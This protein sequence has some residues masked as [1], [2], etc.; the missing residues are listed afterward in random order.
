[1]KNKYGKHSYTKT[2]PKN[3]S[4]YITL[5]Q[6]A[7]WTLENALVTIQ[8]P[9]SIPFLVLLSKDGL[10][11]GDI[12]FAKIPMTLSMWM[13]SMMVLERWI[14]NGSFN[15]EHMAEGEY[16]HSTAILIILHP[17]KQGT[18]LKCTSVGLII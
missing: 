5:F 18:V 1:M 14:A 13:V 2:R 4:G 8:S 10:C 11:L 6:M 17:N 3:H 16:S 12:C 15:P 7:G 9:P